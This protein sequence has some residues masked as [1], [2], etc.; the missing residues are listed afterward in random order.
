MA[1][2]DS[3]PWFRSILR[4]RGIRLCSVGVVKHPRSL[5]VCRQCGHPS[6][7][8]AAPG[9]A[10]GKGIAPWRAAEAMQWFEEKPRVGH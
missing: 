10:A 2:C 1:C 4:V 6:D 9:F 5:L 3:S 8:C 7:G